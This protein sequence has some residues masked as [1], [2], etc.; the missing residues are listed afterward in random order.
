MNIIY[1]PTVKQLYEYAEDKYKFSNK[2]A[3]VAYS[4]KYTGRTPKDKRVVLNNASQDIWWGDINKPINEELFYFYYLHAHNILNKSDTTFIVDS[5]AG[6]D[7]NNRIKV[8]TICN[9]PYHALFIRNMLIPSETI[10]N[11]FDIEILNCGHIKLNSLDKDL[12]NN[13]IE[14]DNS[15]DEALIALD[16]KAGKVIIYGSEYAGEMKKSVLTYMF[17]KMQTERKLTLHS[18]VCVNPKNEPIF[19]FG[20]SGTGK[21]TLSSH[22]GMKLIGDDEHVWTDDGIFN[23]EGGCY[24]KCIGLSKENEPQIYNCI[25]HGAVLE[26]I[27]MNKDGEVDFD[28]TT[29]TKN[30]RCAY[31]LNHVDDVIIPAI[32]GH[33]KDIIFLACDAFGLLP[34]VSKLNYNQAIYY[35]LL[36]YTCKMPGTEMN[37]TKPIKTFSTCFAAPFLIWQPEKYGKL[38]KEKLEKHNCNVWLLNTGWIGGEY[39]VGKRISLKY[40]RQMVEAISN[41][42]IHKVQLFKYPGMDVQVPFS[43]YDIP[44]EVLIPGMSWENSYDYNDKLNKLLLEFKENF[45][46]NYGSEL[47]YELNV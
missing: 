40:T 15:L 19:F 18:S 10:H 46:N 29:I 23:V 17:Y 41:G 20:L 43:L 38:L 26:N 27:V 30:T 7:E 44:Q 21:T 37:I 9:N 2:N 5:Y 12:K 24:A 6:W 34:P 35:F 3:L 25:K 33:P 22:P 16:L 47:Y 1:N 11:T 4:G 31:P 13:N 32:T 39:G 42:D 45:I 28:D 14:K 8:R 36:G